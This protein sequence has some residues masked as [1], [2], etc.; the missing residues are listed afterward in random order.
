MPDG[1][2]EY[3]IYQTMIGAWP[4]GMDRLWP[5]IE[6][7]VR[8]AKQQ[9]SW[10]APNEPF[11]TALRRFLEGI[12]GDAEFLN[13]FELFTQSLIEAAWTSGLSQVLLKLTAPGVPDIYQGTEIW[14]FSLVDPDNRRPVDYKLRRKMLAELD[15]LTP[16]QIWSRASDGLPK[17]WTIRQALRE[18]GKFGPYQPIPVKGARAEHA[19]AFFRGPGIAVIAPRLVLGL[20]GQWLDTCLNLPQGEWNNVLS[21]EEIAGGDIR[22]A[23]VLGSFPVALLVKR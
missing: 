17:L 18:R 13:D 20:N 22:L 15:H 23:E 7:A 12:L 9:T 3:L 10:A 6:K 19:V 16:Q 4:I 8:E 5:Y 2:T 1:N 14:D 21:G 11:E